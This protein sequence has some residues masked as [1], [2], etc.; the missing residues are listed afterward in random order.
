[1]AHEL[2][3]G[4]GEQLAD[5]VT[6]AGVEVID[7]QD[8]VAF[9]KQSAAK[10]R[11]DESGTVRHQHASFSKHITNSLYQSYLIARASDP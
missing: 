6:R 8:I 4:I 1:M 10:V 3:A 9:V 7:A 11:A 5:V 2:K